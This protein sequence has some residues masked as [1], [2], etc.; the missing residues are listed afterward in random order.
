M[1]RLPRNKRLV[2]QGV[3]RLWEVEDDEKDGRSTE[4]RLQSS[5]NLWRGLLSWFKLDGG[6]WFTTKGPCRFRGNITFTS[7]GHGSAFFCIS[8][9]LC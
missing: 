4:F 1:P 6:Y 8:R 7:Q 2:S 9:D 5:T 3:C